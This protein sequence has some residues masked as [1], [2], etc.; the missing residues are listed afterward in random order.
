MAKIV[1]SQLVDDVKNKVGESVFTSNRFGPVVRKRVKPI[2]PRSAGQ[3]NQRAMLRSLAQSWQ[4]IGQ[5]NILA[6]NALAKQITKKDKMGRAYNPTGEDLYIGHNI[7]ILNAGGTQITT[8]PSIA[9]NVVANIAG[10][11]FATSGA[12]WTISGTVSP[13][14]DAQIELRSCGVVSKG[15][16]FQSKFKTFLTADCHTA[17]PLTAVVAPAFLAA[18]G[19]P[20]SAGSVTFV[21]ARVIDKVT[22][23]ASLYQKYRIIGG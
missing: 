18:F 21:D 5:D 10:L 12:A 6:W 17:L 8:P 3:T 20:M 14:V 9:A 13:I 23:F 7:N 11:G 4:G 16:T 15:K 19:T 2:N 1:F 22:G